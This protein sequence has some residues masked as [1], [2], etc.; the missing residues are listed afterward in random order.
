MQLPTNYTLPHP[1]PKRVSILPSTRTATPSW[2]FNDDICDAETEAQ[3]SARDDD[4]ALNEVIM[5]L[6]LKDR[7]TVGCAYYIAREEKL[8]LAQD[9]KMGGLDMIKMSESACTISLYHV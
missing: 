1:A 4:D 9:I 3:M 7:N 2:A 6:D 5:A 8:C